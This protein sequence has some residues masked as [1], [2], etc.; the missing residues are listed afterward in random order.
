VLASM[1]GPS[2]FRSPIAPSPCAAVARCSSMGHGL[3]ALC[4][5]VHAPSYTSSTAQQ[6]A[7]RLTAAA[8]AASTPLQ[9]ISAM[10]VR[11]TPLWTM[12]AHTPLPH[13]H[14]HTTQ[15]RRMLSPSKSTPVCLPRPASLPAERTAIPVLPAD[16][17]KLVRGT[18]QCTS[19]A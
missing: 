12:L 14:H 18:G 16:S 13:R 5:P 1:T 7:D 10:C 4:R 15:M 9:G 8:H 17:A 2:G 11:H 3:Q 19:T 6:D